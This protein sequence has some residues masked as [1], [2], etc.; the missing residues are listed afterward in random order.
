MTKAELEKQ[1]AKQAARIA[2]LEEQ[3]DEFE[4]ELGPHQY[5]GHE[6]RK[7]LGARFAAAGWQPCDPD[8]AHP[9]RSAERHGTHR[10]AGRRT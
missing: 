3:K 2:E 10:P 5:D 4:E 1:L 6:H 9:L 8:R 7:E